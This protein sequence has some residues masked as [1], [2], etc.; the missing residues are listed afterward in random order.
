VRT[1]NNAPQADLSVAGG[2]NVDQDSYNNGT[3][4][5]LLSFGSYSGEGIG[6]QRSGRGNPFG[7]DFYTAYTKRLSIAQTGEVTIG[8]NSPQGLVT[9]FGDSWVNWPTLALHEAETTDYARVEFKAGTNQPWHIAAGSSANVMNFWNATANDNV[10]TLTTN[11][12]LFVKVLTITGGAEVAEPFELS[13]PEVAEGM[14]IVIDR[15][16]PGRLK[17]SAKAYDKR[18]AGIVSGAGGVQPGLSLRQHGVLE[19]GRPVALTGRVYVWADA[20]SNPIEPG[21]LLTTSDV[22]GHAMKVMDHTRAQGAILGKA[23]SE[24]KTGQGLVL[25]LVTLQWVSAERT[26][27]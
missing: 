11:G 12:T 10:M 17:Q 24:L 6:S 21:D 5:N 15:E 8:T 26:S 9:I 4:T 13:Q 7:L 20:S 16:H 18:V 25:V 3:A 27:P 22:P 14:V 23:M 19:C 2:M 1:N